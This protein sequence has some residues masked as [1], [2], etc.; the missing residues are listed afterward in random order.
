MKTLKVGKD[1]SQ[2]FGE[3]SLSTFQKLMRQQKQIANQLFKIE[4]KIIT[5]IS[6]VNRSGKKKKYVS[7]KKKQYVPR[8]GNKLTLDEAIQECMVPNKEMTAGTVMKSLKKNHLYSTKSKHLRIAI[9]NVLNRNPHIITKVGRGVFKYVP[10][11]S[12]DTS[13]EVKDSGIKRGR[14]RPRKEQITPE[15]SS[16]QTVKRGRGRP[17]KV[18]IEAA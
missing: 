15:K 17:R 6:K 11:N 2:L 10:E 8:M 14:G 18:K 13:E 5:G 9:S 4:E 1:A 7:R 12:A 16:D 3:R